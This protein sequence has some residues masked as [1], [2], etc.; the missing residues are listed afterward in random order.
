MSGLAG[1]GLGV[2]TDKPGAGSDAAPAKP[3]APPARPA[4]AVTAGVA[5]ARDVPIYLD[6]IGKC[7]AREVVSIQPQVSGRI[8]EIFFNDGAE[9][10]KGDKLFTIDSRP[11]LVQL[12]Q[13]E[14]ELTLNKASLEQAEAVLFQQTAKI[15]EAK[16]GLAQSKSRLELNRMEFERAKNLLESNA[17]A[18]QEFD[19]KKMAVSVGESLV[20]GSEASVAVVEAQTKQYQ[21]AIA[22]AKAHINAAQASIQAV[23]I[24]LD[25]TTILSPINGRAGQRLVD[26]GNVVTANMGSL[27]VIQSL[28]PIY[29][30]FMIPE[31]QLGNVR[32]NMSNGVLKVQCQ[33]PDGSV[34]T[35][36]DAK[37]LHEG[38]LSFF[39][40]AV[41][42]GSGTVKLRATMQNSDRYFWPGQFVKVRLILG[43][44]KDAVLVPTLA[45][46]VGQAGPFVYVVKA[47]STVEL[48]QIKMGQRHG[49]LVA[50]TEGVAKNESVV[51]TGQMMC[52]PGS[53]VAVQKPDAPAQPVPPAPQA[54]PVKE[55]ETA[56][57][58]GTKQ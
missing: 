46:Q 32:A 28:D 35:L 31:A 26:V 49:N 5:I 52:Q 41:Q 55:K 15:D 51:T 57:P 13:A 7:V 11:F 30:D 58:E 17:V 47:D 50:I 44:Q 29:A 27:L 25:Y 16:A 21:A 14:A 36:D 23:K 48:R 18:K 53:L 22:V 4:A 19:S 20:T 8:T 43:T 24:N 37:N 34:S 40:T 12:E 45:P 9:L 3:D 10:K 33:V 56:A 38:D 39:D 42:D 2:K 54:K 1:C 6:E